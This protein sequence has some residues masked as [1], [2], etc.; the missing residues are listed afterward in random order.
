MGLWG[1]ESGG[2]AGGGLSDQFTAELSAN[3]ATAINGNPVVL[4]F[5]QVV[6]STAAYSIIT[7]KY[8]IPSSGEYEFSSQI[9]IQPTE[10]ALAQMFV[11]LGGVTPTGNA[12][13]VMESI[14]SSIQTL[15]CKAPARTYAINDE[16]TVVFVWS[17]PTI[18]SILA[19][20]FQSFFTGRK[21]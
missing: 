4:T 18:Q 13:I 7:G 2:G 8:I 1:S 3:V 12:T 21:I 16:L 11:A 19:A 17:G 6:K 14:P 9:A 10:T 15:L 5:D 20:N